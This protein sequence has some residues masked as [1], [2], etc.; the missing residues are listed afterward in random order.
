[1]LN[2]DEVLRTVDELKANLAASTLTLTEVAH[3][4]SFTTDDIRAV[5]DVDHV[6]PAD[7][8]L[9]RDYLEQAVRDRG[10]QPTAFTV[11]TESNRRRARSWFLLRA[12]PRHDFSGVA[13]PA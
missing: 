6:D 9:L 8:W 10:D 13:T 1:M 5:L 7:V 3:D 11:L 4:L 12:A 2:A